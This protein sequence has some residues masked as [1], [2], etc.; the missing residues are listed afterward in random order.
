MHITLFTYTSNVFTHL[1][2]NILT[3]LEVLSPAALTESIR[4]TSPHNA[5]K[6]MQHL[7]NQ[8]ESTLES[9]VSLPAP[10]RTII[11]SVFRNS[12]HTHQYH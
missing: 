1:D 10:A 11:Y 4:D 5:N 7:S 8:H 2:I 9:V 3:T 12:M 6:Y